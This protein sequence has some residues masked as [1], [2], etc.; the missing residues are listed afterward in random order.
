MTPNTDPRI[1]AAAKAV[2]SLCNSDPWDESDEVR[3][4]D[5]RD[6][7]QEAAAHIH[8][9]DAVDPLRDRQKLIT[10]MG[11]GISKSHGTT[12]PIVH[13]D[14]EGAI[15][16]RLPALADI[17][18]GEEAS[19]QPASTDRARVRASIDRMRAEGERHFNEQVAKV[20]EDTGSTVLEML[21]A[22]NELG[23]HQEAVIYRRHQN[24]C[25]L[26]SHG[27]EADQ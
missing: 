7:L 21:E 11:V 1:E 9:A 4:S 24:E 18:T 10:R 5:R 20:Q 27:Q 12:E 22:M 23:L 8:A 6:F 2:W 25:M 17:I 3:A 15:C 26:D 16:Y 19:A 14:D 13:I